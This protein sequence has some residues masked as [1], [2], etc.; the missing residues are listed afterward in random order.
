M[1]LST[2]RDNCVICTEPMAMEVPST[3][4]KCATFMH[5]ECALNYLQSD[6]LTC[7]QCRA[8]ESKPATLCG[9]IGIAYQDGERSMQNDLEIVLM[10]TLFAQNKIQLLSLL[11]NLIRTSTLGYEPEFLPLRKENIHR[12]EASYT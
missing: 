2:P 9:M 7:P 4:G 3:C 6:V 5:V 1:R 11:V 8:P 10:R 12:F